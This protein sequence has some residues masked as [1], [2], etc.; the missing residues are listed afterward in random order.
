MTFV[1]ISGS[2]VDLSVPGTVALMSILVLKLTPDLGALAVLVAILPAVAIG[3]ANGGLV[4][5]GANPVLVTLGIQTILAGVLLLFYSGGNVYGQVGSALQKFGDTSF[6]P[7]PAPVAVFLVVAV[8]AHLLL[9]RTTFGFQLY[10]VGANRAAA[11]VS[12]IPVRRIITAVFVI[13]GVLAGL[14]GIVLSAYVNSSSSASGQ[15]YEFDALTGVVVGGTSLFGGMGGIGRTVAGI[16][17][18]GVIT[19]IMILT[20][21]RPEVQYLIKGSLIILAVAVDAVLRR[22]MVDA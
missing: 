7:V 19:N 11:R 10:A 12:G 21:V 22:Q 17:L 6:G 18:I 5:G 14:A 20:G 15:G 8:A 16:L 3:L 2:F 1:V 13:S 9:Q 4:A